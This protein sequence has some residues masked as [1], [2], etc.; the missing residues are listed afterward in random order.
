MWI[1]PFH[2]FI[3]LTPFVLAYIHKFTVGRKLQLGEFDYYLL[4]YFLIFGVGLQGLVTGIMQIFDA[5]NH[6]DFANRPWSP[7]VW[8][9]G[10][11]NISYGFL[12]FL[13]IWLRGSFWAAAGLGYSLFL[14]MSFCGH[15]YEIYAHENYSQGNL[16][17]H[18]WIDLFTALI[19]FTLI[20]KSK[21][22]KQ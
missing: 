1:V 22:E 16:G 10:M 13:C 21:Y 7:F 3:F 11:M 17:V 8:E 4:L 5:E 2:L 15:L 9:V 14:L 18:V 20:F 12:G 6:A 19:I